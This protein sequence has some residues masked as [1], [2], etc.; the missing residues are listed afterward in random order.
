MNIFDQL[1]VNVKANNDT[2]LKFIGKIESLARESEDKKISDFVDKNKERIIKGLS[3]LEENSNG[4]YPAIEKELSKKTSRLKKK[5][6]ELE[7]AHENVSSDN[8]ILEFKKKD[9][10]KLTSDLEEAYDKIS[11]RTDELK[12]AHA[13]IL[14]KNKELELGKE[15]LLDQTDYLHEANET[16]SRMHEEVQQ[17]REVILR[18]NEELQNLNNE[19]NNLIGIVA[20]DLKSPLNQIKGLVTLVRVSSGNLDKE[21]LQYIDMMEG[22]LN[23]LSNMI[24]KILDVEAIESKKLNLKIESADITALVKSV[25]SRFRNEAEQK[26]ISLHDHVDDTL[27]ANIDKDYADQVF[28]NLISNAIKFSKHDK[29]VF[30]SLTSRDTKVICE[31]RDEGPGLSEDDKKK[32]FGKYQKL[33]AKPT[34]NE[35][36][37][38]LG[39][40]I[41]KKFVESMNGEIWCE[42][43]EGKGA[44]FFV[45]F[46]RA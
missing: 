17:Q 11:K 6:N 46:E 15:A 3:L 13:Q 44:S 40:S 4:L 5:L 41:V 22:S 21:T 10:L 32:L 8:F 31:V 14:E 25:I 33:S 28:Q 42:S 38:G 7:R 43:E 2:L 39:L 35:T 16:I 37:T 19:K 26:K 29:N 9:L 20:H 36:S 34:G 23:K 30:I 45:S 1:K 18:K 12:I 24:G 27:F